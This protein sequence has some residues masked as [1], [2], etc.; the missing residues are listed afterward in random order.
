MDISV[1]K[2][3][4]GIEK[5]LEYISIQLQISKEEF[6]R[7]ST[8]AFLDKKARE[9]NSEILALAGK[10]GVHS[11]QEFENLY[12]EGKLEEAGTWE[13]FQKF[14]HLEFKRDQ[15]QKLKKEFA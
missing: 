1:G 4:L 9:I 3:T 5:S 8:I 11:I 2:E 13:D 15:I 7:Q 6:L 12:K 14:D 10:Y